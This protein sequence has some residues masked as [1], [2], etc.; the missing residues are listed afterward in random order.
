MGKNEVLCDWDSLLFYNACLYI[1][2]KLLSMETLAFPKNGR[3]P[4]NAKLMFT[5]WT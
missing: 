5:F 3:F 2:I 4:H 1:N